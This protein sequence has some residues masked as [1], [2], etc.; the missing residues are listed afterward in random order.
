MARTLDTIGTTGHPSGGAP[1]FTTRRGP[2]FPYAAPAFVVGIA[3]AGAA[4]VE[5]ADTSSASQV[6]WAGK[7][8]GVIWGLDGLLIGLGPGRDPLGLI[9]SGVGALGAA[10]LAASA[11]TGSS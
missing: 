6:R 5:L 4:I 10:V 7:V 2:L 1:A 11:H 8:V 9:V 3:A